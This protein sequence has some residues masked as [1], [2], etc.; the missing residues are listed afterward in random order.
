MY[1]QIGVVF[2]IVMNITSV[3]LAQSAQKRQGDVQAV[4]QR[5][6][7]AFNKGDGSGIAAL[8]TA[9]GLRIGPSGGLQVGR[10]AIAEAYTMAFSGYAKGAQIAFH[11][12]QT[13]DISSN[14]RVV[15]GTYEV[16]GTPD[17]APH[18]RFL[19]TIVRQGG[20]WKLASL[21]AV[22][23]ARTEKPAKAP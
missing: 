7:A 10:E 3:S 11:P 5:Y 19:T 15:A 18:G 23:V 6:E 9:D 17:I 22:P 14:V 4:F 2:A 12:S 20:H 1:K 8:Y 16:V 13:R 21:A